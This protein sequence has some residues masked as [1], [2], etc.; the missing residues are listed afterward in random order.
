[1]SLAI[2][3]FFLSLFP[4]QRADIWDSDTSEAWAAEEWA[5]CPEDTEHWIHHN[6]QRQSASLHG[7]VADHPHPQVRRILL[8]QI[9]DR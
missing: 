2:I 1:M 4:P 8:F 3:I 7:H 9:S 6:N 5:W